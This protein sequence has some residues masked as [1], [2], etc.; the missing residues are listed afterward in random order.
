[1]L[2]A[3][4]TSTAWDKVQTFAKTTNHHLTISY[5]DG[6]YHIDMDNSDIAGA[7]PTI[8]DAA[9]DF[10]SDLDMNTEDHGK[11][12]NPPK[13]WTKPVPPPLVKPESKDWI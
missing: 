8:E 11:D 1:M 5:I 12:V 13:H 2:T 6:Y 7:G 10:L 9:E 4:H 3:A